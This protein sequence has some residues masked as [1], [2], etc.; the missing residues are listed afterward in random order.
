MMRG[1][2]RRVQG[3]CALQ[4]ALALRVVALV[5]DLELRERRAAVPDADL[6]VL[7]CQRV[8]SAS[9]AKVVKFEAVSYEQ[10]FAPGI[11]LPGRVWASLKPTWIPDVAKDDNFPRAPVAVAEGL[12]GAF[13]FPIL[14]GQKFLAMME[15]FSH[16]IREPEGSNLGPLDCRIEPAPTG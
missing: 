15:F 16:E 3:E 12:H 14:S 9:S 2:V 10:T 13:A 11:G 8:W 4:L 7:A 5:I 1:R 6:R